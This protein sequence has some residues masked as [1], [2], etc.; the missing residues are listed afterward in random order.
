MFILKQYSTT[1]LLENI[2]RHGL[3]FI[4]FLIL[5]INLDELVN[6]LYLVYGYTDLGKI[7]LKNGQARKAYGNKK[8][9]QQIFSLQQSC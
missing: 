4:I 1:K 6:Q 3:F 7:L 8:H 9:L 5:S 2:L